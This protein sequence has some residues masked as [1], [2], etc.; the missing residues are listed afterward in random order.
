[1]EGLKEKFD[2][3]FLISHL[4]ISLFIE[5]ENPTYL[6]TEVINKKLK[7]I[8]NNASGII[9]LRSIPEE[10]LNRRLNDRKVRERVVDIEEIYKN[11]TLNDN[12]WNEVCKFVGEEKIKTITNNDNKLAEAVMEGKIFIDNLK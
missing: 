2:F 4:V 6:D 8:L 3:V 11:N 5:K 1:M 9:L 7:Y 10:I 12:K